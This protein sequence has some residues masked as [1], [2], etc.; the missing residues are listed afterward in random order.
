MISARFMTAE[1]ANWYAPSSNTWLA[2]YTC[3]WPKPAQSFCHSRVFHCEAVWCWI[4][5]TLA[6]FT[7]L[8]FELAVKV[9]AQLLPRPADQSVE[10]TALPSMTSPISPVIS[11]AA[12]ICVLLLLSSVIWR[13]TATLKFGG[14]NPVQGIC[15]QEGITHGLHLHRDPST[16]CLSWASSHSLL[17]VWRKL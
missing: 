15:S 9:Q 7:D 4:E 17:P 14:A 11:T 2:L 1:S 13:D 10:I 12:G 3:L 5:N 6:S 16:I 8:S